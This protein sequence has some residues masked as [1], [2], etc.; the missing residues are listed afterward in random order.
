MQMTNLNV[1]WGLKKT[2]LEGSKDLSKMILLIREI[3][4]VEQKK[5]F[6]FRRFGLGMQCGLG[7]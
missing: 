7:G 5:L 4:H 3:I 2:A 1:F 6:V